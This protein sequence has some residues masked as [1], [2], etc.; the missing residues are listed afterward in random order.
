M[1]TNDSCFI[2]MVYRDLRQ[3]YMLEMGLS[4]V[5][6]DNE[7]LSIVYHVGVHVDF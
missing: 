1:K 3:T 2:A 6:V 4:Q 7:T 5:L